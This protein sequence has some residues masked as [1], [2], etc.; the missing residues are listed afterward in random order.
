MCGG[1]RQT[2]EPSGRLQWF[3]ICRPPVT[4]PDRVLAL[5]QG[6]QVPAAILTSQ[7]G[8]GKNESANNV[9]REKIHERKMRKRAV[10]EK[11]GAKSRCIFKMEE[12]RACVDIDGKEL[13][14]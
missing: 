12:T 6:V 14:E 10:L 9:N 5:V 8:N 4:W 7:G 11:R 1:E 13:V 3:L 2:P